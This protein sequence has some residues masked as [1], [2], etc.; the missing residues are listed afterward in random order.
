[1]REHFTDDLYWLQFDLLAAEPTITHGVFSRQGGVS[2][3]PFLGLNAGSGVGDDQDAVTENR[4]RIVAALPGHPTLVTVHP[5][6]SNQVIEILPEAVQEGPALTRL[7]P[8]RADA[9]ITRARG[10]G[11]FWAYADCAPILLVD[12]EHDAIALVHAGWR[13]T[14]QAVV[15]AAMSAMTTHYGTR[16]NALIVG[17]G[18]TI[19]AC[20]YEVDGPV[21]QAF[22][23]HPFALEHAAFSTITVTD[24]SDTRKQSLRLDVL[25]SNYRQLRALDIPSNQ[26]ERC[27]LCTGCHTDLFFSFRKEHRQTGRH[28]VVIALR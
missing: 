13:G 7:I 21:S 20:C 14:S 23:A 6:H 24:E 4:R 3:P 2:Q 16:P 10:I 17:L 15:A 22:A 18:P 26:I 19:G 8:G 12:R 11:L 28:A 9:M 5:V 27:D 25:E 1:M